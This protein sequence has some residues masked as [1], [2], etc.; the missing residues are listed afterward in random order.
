MWRREQYSGQK[1]L[2]TAG[3]APEPAGGGATRE[4]R[5]GALLPRPKGRLSSCLPLQ[6]LRARR[7]LTV[8]QG[9]VCCPLDCSWET[10][11]PSAK[12]G[13]RETSSAPQSWDIMSEDVILGAGATVLLP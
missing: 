7:R 11:L 1:A 2:Q 6:R 8:G 9:K 5:G 12:R 4:Q 13:M 3:G 10:F